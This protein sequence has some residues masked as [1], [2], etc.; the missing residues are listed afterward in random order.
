MF[1]HNHR[2]Q[3]W[4]D[5]VFADPQV[6]YDLRQ[7]AEDNSFNNV[8]LYGPYGSAK[9]SIAQVMVASSYGKR[10]TD[11]VLDITEVQHD[12]DAR[13]Q[14]FA[15]GTR[16]GFFAMSNQTLKPYA[17]INEVD[18]FTR[19]QQLKFRGII[20][21]QVNGRFVFT[22]NNIENV[23][24]GLVDRCDCYE[25]DIPPPDALLPLAQKI[26]TA[27]GVSIDD[28]TLL[29]MMTQMGGSMRTTMKGLEKLILDART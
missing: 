6:E 1:A 26:C 8:L 20:D 22:T 21:E 16:Y 12:I 23:D 7:Y 29:T 17:I 10:V 14:S 24:R 27:E 15:D 5:L 19:T 3:I 28:N 4:S 13:L 9:S 2:A 25:I 18:E 11:A